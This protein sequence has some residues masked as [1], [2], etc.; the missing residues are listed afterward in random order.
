MAVQTSHELRKSN[1]ATPAWP[2]VATPGKLVVWMI[3]TEI[4]ERKHG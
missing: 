1:E 2:D 4:R 3:K